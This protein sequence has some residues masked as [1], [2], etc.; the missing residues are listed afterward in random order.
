MLLEPFIK[1]RRWV[2]HE[3]EQRELVQDPCVERR[4]FQEQH[5]WLARQ[6]V[7]SLERLKLGEHV[8]RERLGLFLLEDGLQPPGQELVRLHEIHAPDD[9]VLVVFVRMLGHEMEGD[10]R[11]IR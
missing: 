11:R 5:E 1:T 2:L 4:W 6:R 3:R 10:K 7:E 9:A 8:D